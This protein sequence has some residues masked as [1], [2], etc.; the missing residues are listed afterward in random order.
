MDFLLKNFVK[1]SEDPAHIA[2][3]RILLHTREHGVKVYDWLR[4]IQ[5]L[6]RTL[7]EAQKKS[8]KVSK[9]KRK[10]INELLIKQVTDNEQIQIGM[11]DDAY[12]ANK[13]ITGSFILDDLVSMIAKNIQKFNHRPY[14]VPPSIKEYLRVRDK[15]HG[16]LPN[17]PHPIKKR[18]HRDIYNM[19][20]QDELVERD[21]W[22]DPYEDTEGPKQPHLDLLAFRQRPYEH[23]KCTTAYCIAQKID[24]THNT[25]VCFNKG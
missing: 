12:S 25:S 9:G 19:E 20:I 4:S 23:R 5:P 8:K 21:I 10:R 11:L 3:T 16:K 6:V 24:H 17:L 7:V 2:W 22:E 1:T 15:Q 14:H 18:K 13:L